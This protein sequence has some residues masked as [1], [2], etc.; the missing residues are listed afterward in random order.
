MNPID[1]PRR[2]ER[3]GI[4]YPL[5]LPVS[6]KFAHKEM[7]ARSENISLRGILL[8]S[9]FLVP[10]GSTVEVAVGVAQLPG[11]GSQLSARGQVLRVHPK[12]TGDFSVAIAF[13]RPFRFGGKGLDSAANSPKVESALPAAKNRI[14]ACPRLA[15]AW[16]T[17]T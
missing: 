1:S 9:A 11:S 5:H 13:E 17:E 14:S 2:T 12:P 4:R 10:E 3:R 6:L 7:H 15:W 8:S 16:H